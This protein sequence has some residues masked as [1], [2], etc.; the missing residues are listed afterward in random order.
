MDDNIFFWESD[1]FYFI[2]KNQK[3]INI[4]QYENQYQ[5]I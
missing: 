1:F 4:S 2:N 5:L 3:I